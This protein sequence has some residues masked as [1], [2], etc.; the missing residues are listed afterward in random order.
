MKRGLAMEVVSLFFACIAAGFLL[1]PVIKRVF[2]RPAAGNYDA[3]EAMKDSMR[4]MKSFVAV[5]RRGL[6]RGKFLSKDKARSG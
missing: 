4:K 2:P 1:H 6:K 3:A 5:P